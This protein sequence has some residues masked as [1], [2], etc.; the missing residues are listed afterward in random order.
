MRNNCFSKMLSWMAGYWLAAGFSKML[1]WMAGYWL[2]A[3]W[4]YR[5]PFQSCTCMFL[6]FGQWKS[7]SANAK[8][9]RIYVRTFWNSCK[10]LKLVENEAPDLARPQTRFFQVIQHVPSFCHLRPHGLSI[11][12]DM[13]LDLCVD[14]GQA[15]IPTPMQIKQRNLFHSGL[16]LIF[17]Y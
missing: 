9:I 14:I 4:L 7:S 16:F 6:M 2:A 12:R 8:S 5:D 17:V 1:S 11:R 15:S 3:G 13:C 10:T